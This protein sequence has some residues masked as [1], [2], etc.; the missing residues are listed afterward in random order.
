[1]AYKYVFDP[2][3]A[4]EYEN[5][6]SWDQ[7]RSEMAADNLLVAIEESI[8]AIC[9]DPYRY[10]NTYKNLRELALKKYPY[11]I[12]YFID[13]DKKVVTITSLFHDKRNPKK[14]Y[15]K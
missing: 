9:T 13:E 2:I 12:I 6:F 5:A 1:M 8:K 3:A 10:R 4:S 11:Y 15:K 7:E 14:K